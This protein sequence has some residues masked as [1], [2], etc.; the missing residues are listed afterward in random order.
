MLVDPTTGE[1]TALAQQALRRAGAPAA[2]GDGAD[3][4]AAVEAELYQQQI[5]IATPPCLDLGT[6]RSEIVRARSVVVADVGRT[7]AVAVASPTPL[8]QRHPERVTPKPRYHRIHDEYGEIARQAL[9]CGMHVHVAVEEDE[10]VDVVDAVQPWLPVLLAISANSPFFRES[11]TG[12]ASWRSHVWSRW[13]TSGPREPFAD[14]AAYDE[15]AR[16]LQEWGA[17]LDPGMLYFDVRGA[18]D[19][20][21]V[22]IRV[23]DVCTEVDDSLLVAA[24]SRALI[25]TVADRRGQDPAPGHP[26]WRSDLLRA[27]QWRASRYGMAG[28]LVHP[29]RRTLAPARDV[30]LALVEETG[31]ALDE[32]GDR[33]EVLALLE[34]LLSRGS[35][36]ARQRAVL[37][38]EGT[39]AAVVADLARRTALG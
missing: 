36:A 19:H 34:R 37:A 33:E 7:G 20:P 39:Y 27:A 3:G 28:T 31:D 13:P 29:L 9:V 30:V 22:E 25:T 12:Y 21:T 11:D 35:G 38:A 5:E 23:A 24:L 17:A 18:R 1:V 8:V 2:A 16:L 15:T 10:V 26:A 4:T 6:L 14:R 32:A